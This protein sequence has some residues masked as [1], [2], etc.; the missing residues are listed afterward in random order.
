[1]DGRTGETSGAITRISLVSLWPYASC[2]LCLLLASETGFPFVYYRKCNSGLRQW[3]RRDHVAAS[4]PS[5]DHHCPHHH[6]LPGQEQAS[7]ARR[8]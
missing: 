4:P 2:M 3:L 1:M 8:V 5:T 6:C 7:R